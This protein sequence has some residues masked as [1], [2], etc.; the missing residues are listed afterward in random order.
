MAGSFKNIITYSFALLILLSACARIGR[1]SGGEKDTTPPRLL[2]SVPARQTTNFKGKE[3]TLEFDEYVQIKDPG[4]NLLISPPLQQPPVIIPAGIASKTFKIK[5]QD[6]LKPNTTYLINFGNSIADYNEGNKLSDFQLVFSTGPVIDSLTLKGKLHPVYYNGKTDNMMVGLYPADEFKD[7][8]VFKQKPYYVAT[9]NAKTGDFQLKYLRQGRYRIIGIIDENHDYK[10]RKGEEAIGFTDKIIEIPGDTLVEL[11]L[12]KE[13]PRL[14]FEKIEQA[15]KNHVWIE[16]KGSIDSL[17]VQSLDSLTKEI[18]IVD[19]NKLH[20]WYDTPGDSI[21]LAL[22]LGKKSKKYIRKRTKKSDSLQVQITSV[23]NPLDTV[24]ISANIPLADFDKSKIKLEA[25]SLPVPFELALTSRYNYRVDFD[26]KTGKTYKVVLLPGAL[27]D[28]LG[29]QL[30]DTLQKKMTIRPEKDF[31]K[32]ILSFKKNKGEKRFVELLKNNKVFRKTP[33]FT[34]DS[35]SIP[36]LPPGKYK[37]RIVFDTNANNLWDTG[38]Y[39]K[40]RQPEKTFEP[41]KEIEIRPN[42]DINQTYD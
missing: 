35:I 23:G 39:L 21:K 9:A 42:W 10:Y 4:K 33:T 30:K 20:F 1:P 3:L 36:Y 14:G 41:D 6:S 24:R 8:L 31:G 11:Y 38:D 37:I 28:F 34:S 32:L 19:G 12:F 29:N 7:S 2:K 22:Q 5:F 40:H 18:R 13:P 26:K 25:D 27:T 15:G 17:Q 16:V